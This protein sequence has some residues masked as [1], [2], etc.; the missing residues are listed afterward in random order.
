M[1]A[2]GGALGL[3]LLFLPLALAYWLVEWRLVTAFLS[4]A[5]LFPFIGVVLIELG[6]AVFKAKE[7]DWES[8]KFSAFILAIGSIYVYMILVLPAFLFLRTLPIAIHW[9]FPAMVTAIVFVVFFLLKNSR[10][11]DAATI[12]VITICSC[13]HSWMILGV[14]YLLKKI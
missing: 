1:N 13:L 8:A 10:P 11:A 6:I 3:L 7:F 14:Y 9:S 4:T 5:I 2:I 12:T